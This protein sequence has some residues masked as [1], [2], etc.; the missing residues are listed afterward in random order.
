MQLYVIQRILGLLLMLF[1]FTMLP[2]VLVSFYYHEASVMPFVAAFMLTFI[3]GTFFWLPVRGHKADLRTREGFLVV[4]LF[5]VVLSLFGSLPLL[6]SEQP[7]I[8]ITDSVF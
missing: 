6:L 5:W 3:T 4:V 2:P 8:T 1:S 7:S